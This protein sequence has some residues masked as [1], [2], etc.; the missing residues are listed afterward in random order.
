MLAMIATLVAILLLSGFGAWAVPAQVPGHALSAA[1]ESSAMSGPISSANPSGWS[2]PSRAVL[3]AIPVGSQPLGVGMD[4]LTDTAYVANAGSNNVSVIDGATDTVTANVPVGSNPM[5]VA[6]D[7]VSDTIYVTN[8][9]SDNVSVIDGAT[10]T[11]TANVPVGSYPTGVGVDRTTDTIYVANRNSN[12][13]SV[14]NGT[15]N[16]VTATLLVGGQPWGV[17]VDSVTDRI[18]VTDCAWDTVSVINGSANSISATISVGQCPEG[19]GVNERT[20]DIYVANTWS[21]SVSMIDG[22]SNSVWGNPTVSGSPWEIGVD[23][24]TNTLYVAGRGANNL[25][26][27]SGSSAK[28]TAAE[29]VGPGLW[30]VGVDEITDTLYVAS[31]LSDSVRV[32]DG[33]T[34]NLTVT[35]PI[36]PPYPSFP[37]NLGVDTVAGRIYV[38]DN[39]QCAPFPTGLGCLTVLNHTTHAVIATIPLQTEPEGLAVDSRTDMIYVSN[40]NGDENNVSVINGTTDTIT[41]SVNVGTMPTGVAV[42]SRTD[43]IYTANTVTNNVSVIDGATNTVTANIP[44]GTNPVQVAVDSLTDT[45]YVTNSGS[46]NLSVI[47]G[48]TNTVVATIPLGSQPG[49]LVVD[50]ATDRI[51]VANSISQNVS[52]IDL[53]TNKVIESITVSQIVSL[54]LMGIAMNYATDTIYVATDPLDSTGVPGQA[55]EINGR[56][57][58]VVAFTTVGYHPRALALDPTTDTLYSANFDGNDISVVNVGTALWVPRPTVTPSSIDSGQSVTFSENGISGGVLPYSYAWSGLPAGCPSSASTFTCNPSSAAP[59]TYA[60][61]LTVTDSLQPS[62]QSRTSAP[63]TFTLFPDP[64]VASAPTASPGSLDLGQAVTFQATVTSPG[65]GGDVYSW[66][67]LPPGC[68]SVNALSVT[69]APA[70]PNTYAVGFHVNDSNGENATSPLLSFVVSP[71]PTVSTLTATRTTLDVGQSTVLSLLSTNGTGLPSTYAWFGLPNGCLSQSAA[72]V[73]CSPTANGTFEVTA[74]IQDSNGY[75]VSSSVVVLVVAPALGNPSLSA[76]RAA[77]DVGQTVTLSSTVRGGTG[78]YT[79]SWSNLPTGCVSSDASVLLCA[80]TSSGGVAAKVVVTDSNGASASA[81]VPLTVSIPPT[82]SSITAAPAALDVGQ[83][84][85]L[86]ATATNGTGLASTYA[87]SGLPAGCA[88][89]DKLTVSCAPT[90]A[91]MYSVTV[92]VADSNAETVTSVPVILSVAPALSAP[93]LT[94]SAS[95]LAAG[96]S[97]VFTVTVS[98][99][100]A[101]LSFAWSGLPKGCSSADSQVLACTPNAAGTYTVKVTVTD[102]AGATVSATSTPVTVTAASASSAGTGSLSGLD[103]GLIAAVAILVV[104]VVLLAVLLARKGGRSKATEGTGKGESSSEAASSSSGA[105]AQGSSATEGTEPSPSSETSADPATPSPEPGSGEG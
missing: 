35:I 93:T 65:S 87:W 89:S 85:T 45:I 96:G 3:G 39:F 58:T 60:V 91:G 28:V 26:V 78:A 68:P 92:S 14:I 72:S 97:E 10:D 7:N 77:L 6:V 49:M 5:G 51:Y 11:V 83:S 9:G 57:N 37:I 16:T 66:S 59:G 105:E 8:A 23:M 74:T 56:T 29:T 25:S 2:P 1:A 50:P 86:S 20:D 84:T 61:R 4:V 62:S 27:I 43:T 40:V 63:L 64:A 88:S 22:P 44:V 81:T 69:C 82:V 30:G 75:N 95:T 32:V 47:D 101:P 90:D 52:V 48:T 21:N 38:L 46:D 54:E 33:S 100:T 80:P 53:L 79:Y 24:A 34:N 36:A 70:L 55:I 42:D 103:W 15:T 41:T 17:G 67:G 12:T 19:V 73:V 99:G 94:S 71:D 104:I 31:E 98:G 18:Y 13:V 102:G 76:S